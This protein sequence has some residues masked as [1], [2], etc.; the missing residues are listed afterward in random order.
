M[1]DNSFAVLVRA[2]SGRRIFLFKN[3]T[4]AKY[5]RACQPKQTNQP[6]NQPTKLLQYDLQTFY[7]IG[8]IPDRY[9]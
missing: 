6:T 2:E 7:Q 8:D 5:Q 4:L 1:M 9:L 3:I